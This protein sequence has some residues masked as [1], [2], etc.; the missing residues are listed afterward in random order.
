MQ[1]VLARMR[2]GFVWS[3]SEA[4]VYLEAMSIMA[5]DRSGE[6]SRQHLR[7]GERG[8]WVGVWWEGGR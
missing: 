7:E 1:H 6:V 4:G 2:V 3:E 8:K 5:L